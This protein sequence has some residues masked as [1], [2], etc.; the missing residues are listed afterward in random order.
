MKVKPIIINIL[1]II[2][3]VTD[4]IY[5]Q[6]SEGG[7]PYS[8]NHSV[9][10]VIEVKTMPKVDVEAL[11][12]EDE[13]SSKNEPYRFGYS[14]DVS[15]NLKNSGTWQDLPDG[16]KIWRLGIVS[17]GAFSINLIYD[18]FWLPKGGKFF[19]YNQDKS[20]LIGAFTERN[21]KP[22][23]KFATELVK[24]EA[25]ILE[26]YEPA[27]VTRSGEISISRVVHAYR[28]LFGTSQS[29]RSLGKILGFGDSGE[30][31]NNVYCPE[32]AGWVDEIHSVARI[33]GGNY[34]ASGSLVNNVKENFDPYFLTANHVYIDLP[35][36]STWVFYFNYESDDCQNP[37][38]EPTSQT[39]TGASLKA[40]NSASDFALIMLDKIPPLNYNVYYNGWSNINAAPS[41]SVCIHHPSG[42]IKKISYEND[43]AISATWPETPTNSHWKVIWDD[44]TTEHGSSGS[45]LFNPDHRIVGQLHGG[46]ASCSNP[47]GPDYF[48]KFSMS[49]DYGSSSS[50]RLK[51]W[52]DPNNTGAT[53][54][55]GLPRYKNIYVP[56]DY[57]TIQNAI[58]AAVSG[59]IVHVSSGTYTESISMKE[60]VDVKGS[61][62]SSTTING[63]VY[64]NNDDGAGL[65]DVT[66][67]D[68]I[69][70]N[71]S[72]NVS[73]S[74]CKAGHS[75]CYIDATGSSMLGLG[76]ITSLVSQTRG[77]YAHSGSDFSIISGSWKN[78]MDAV[79]LSGTSDGDMHWV[80]F[81]RN[82]YYDIIASSSTAHAYG[83]TFSSSVP[84]GSVSGNVYWDNWNYCGGGGGFLGKKPGKRANDICNDKNTATINTDDPDFIDY[85]EIMDSYNI[86]KDKFIEDKKSGK[87]FSPLKYKSDLDSVIEQFKKFISKYPDS[88]YAASVLSRMGSIWRIL[89]NFEELSDYIN[90]TANNPK[91]QHLKPYA[92]ST[93]I[94]MYIKMDEYIKAVELYN[95]L[96]EDYP[97]HPM[98]VEWLYGKGIVYKYHMGKPASAEKIFRIII[99]KYPDNPTAQS[100]NDELEYVKHE[101][102]IKK[103]GEKEESEEP[104]N[105][106]VQNYPNPF[107]P[108]TT[109]SFILPEQGYVLVK[110]FDVMGRE[111][112]TITDKKMSAGRH[113]VRWDGKN[114][115]GQYVASGIYFYR[116]KFKNQVLNRKIML[117]R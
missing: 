82:S 50:T 99:E 36:P 13:N 58:D 21:N 84:G 76:N 85:K 31:N 98:A 114:H 49:W 22:N 103:L 2:I 20:M 33:L 107:N 37:D 61:G 1:A 83:C 26:Y 41:S 11:L 57:P 48:S 101:L 47:N 62:Q 88:P 117:V 74:S 72:D 51:D 100:A 7:K 108:E 30:C 109:I 18:K 42:D 28:N 44:G 46:Q 24:G 91:L 27:N 75:N 71:N 43:Q 25:I 4:S 63:R 65:S 110:I 52:L 19:V 94:S 10:S 6:I 45:P 79:Q 93:L 66:V 32:A 81:C 78:K 12:R 115:T 3:C 39:M 67:N 17:P 77:I 86:I 104:L 34:L 14:F 111:I 53:V 16:S 96:I 60:G 59:C 92:L 9:L 38:E 113:T 23:R 106:S 5:A 73:I 116:I 87:R 80:N 105:L 56:Q 64:F 102:P 55:N 90:K 68:K 29:G 112:R 69:S 8:F 35:D 97:D 89:D 54:L 70:V 40:H 95:K 15:Y